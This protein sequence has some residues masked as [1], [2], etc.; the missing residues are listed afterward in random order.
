MKNIWR[1]VK[2]PVY[3]LVLLQVLAAFSYVSGHTEKVHHGEAGGV[4]LMKDNKDTNA[5]D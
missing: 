4:L 1:S 2:V 5:A 3:K